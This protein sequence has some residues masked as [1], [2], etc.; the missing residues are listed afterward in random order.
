VRLLKPP[1]TGAT[2]KACSATRQQLGGSGL[3][4][5][6]P[7]ILAQAEQEVKA[8]QA[9]M[10]EL[11]A[12]DPSSSVEFHVSNSSFTDVPTVLLYK[13]DIH[14]SCSVIQSRL[15]EFAADLLFIVRDLQLSATSTMQPLPDYEGCTL[16]AGRLAV[17]TLQCLSTCRDKLPAQAAV[18]KNLDWLQLSMSMQGNLIQKPTDCSVIFRTCGNAAV[19]VAGSQEQHSGTPANQP[20]AASATKAQ[21]GVQSWRAAASHATDPCVLECLFTAALVAL[22]SASSSSKGKSGGSSIRQQR[23][24][25]ADSGCSNYLAGSQ[26]C[27]RLLL[28]LAYSQNV[29]S[30]SRVDSAEWCGWFIQCYKRIIQREKVQQPVSTKHQELHLLLPP[31]LLAWAASAQP[32]RDAASK[33][34]SPGQE[35]DLKQAAASCSITALQHWVFLQQ[36]QQG[37]VV[38]DPPQVPAGIVGPLLREL[39]PQVLDMLSG[40]VSA[41]NSAA[42]AALSSTLPHA[43]DQAATDAACSLLRW[44]LHHTPATA[45]HNSAAPASGASERGAA[46][47]AAAAWRKH[48]PKLSTVLEALVRSGPGCS[49][50]AILQSSTGSE[51][52]VLQLLLDAAV[53][54]KSTEAQLQHCSLLASL[55][56]HSSAALANSCSA[57]PFHSASARTASSCSSASIT[58][59]QD[60][61]GSSG[62]LWH[63]SQLVRSYGSGAQPAERDG[64][65]LWTQQLWHR[66]RNRQIRLRAALDEARAEQ[67]EQQQLLLLHSQLHLPSVPAVQ[68]TDSGRN[69]SS[70]CGSSSAAASGARRP[71]TAM[72]VLL[73][74]IKAVEEALEAPAAAHTSSMCSGSSIGTAG[75]GSASHRARSVSGSVAAGSSGKIGSSSA[76]GDATSASV[77]QQWQVTLVSRCCAVA[78]EHLPGLIGHIMFGGGCEE[79][80]H[81][82]RQGSSSSTS[83]NSYRQQTTVD[84][85]QARSGDLLWKVMGMLRAWCAQ[86]CE[87]SDNQQLPPPT[88]YN[89]TN[90][91]KAMLEAAALFSAAIKAIDTASDEEAVVKAALHAAE[92]AGSLAVLGRTLG[93]VAT[94]LLCNNPSCSNLTGACELHLVDRGRQ[95]I[96]G[97]CKTSRCCSVA[98]KASHWRVHRRV[99]RQLRQL[100]ATSPEE[101]AGVTG[102]ACERAPQAAAG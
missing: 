45:Q 36:R 25:G 60:F 35:S 34:M 44:L 84:S 29:F 74:T 85:R 99:F 68:R 31:L 100:Q 90:V 37:T 6:L 21:H 54:A 10:A 16:P 88:G 83:T 63:S 32:L 65:T 66:T 8:L 11:P 55:L 78:A 64:S 27:M 38:Q 89:T 19:L 71:S 86:R 69:R 26:C 24:G 4:E 49:L 102:A 62:W 46:L 30:R 40:A 61:A 48:A 5:Q 42:L 72:H 93:A 53:A 82:G 39:L 91:R 7:V 97:K 3:T 81:C 101:S 87:L 43:G 20:P 1:T 95:K 51:A 12:A 98:C 52:V 70:S 28:V 56:K 47:L 14:K 94:P 9:A 50:Q 96:C 2:S 23:Q 76:A 92:F 80:G 75:G 77:L 41:D 13:P 33:Q 18:A 17:A 58:A 22:H 59:G 57:H 79:G 67:K 15:L 73:T